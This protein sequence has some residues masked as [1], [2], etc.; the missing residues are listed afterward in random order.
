MK[1]KL[2]IG[3][4]MWLWSTVIIGQD[5]PL[6]IANEHLAAQ[7]WAEAIP[8]YRTYLAANPKDSSA[9][10][11]LG[12]A[13]YKSDQLDEGWA[14]LERAESL[15]Y[16]PFR[17]AYHQAKVKVLQQD[18]AAALELLAET[19]NNGFPAFQQL[20]TDADFTPLLGKEKFIAI[21][22]RVRHNAL[23]CSADEKYHPLDFWLGEWDVYVNDQ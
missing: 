22:T 12:L 19:A 17:V 8:S 20:A 11:N 16:S 6:E 7:R 9:H 1:W 5:N 18:N 3:L 13:L 14:S 21:L 23:P 2:F 4:G 15:R 10:F